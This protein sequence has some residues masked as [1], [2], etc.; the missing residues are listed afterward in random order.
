MPELTKAK[1][2]KLQKLLNMRYRPSEIADELGVTVKTVYRSYLPSGAPCI[3]EKEGGKEHIWIV[4]DVFAKWAREY[5]TTR[6]RAPKPSIPDGSA[7]CVRCNQV[8]IP[9]D[10]KIG[11]PNSRGVANMNGK[12]PICHGRVNRFLKSGTKGAK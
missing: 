7:Y 8:I 3:K 2:H 10:I 1:V 6:K 5:A 11:R 4:G 12:C 9:L